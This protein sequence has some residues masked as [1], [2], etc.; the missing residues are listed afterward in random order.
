MTKT[1]TDDGWTCPNCGSTDPHHAMTFPQ[2]ERFEDEFE[3]DVTCE[4]VYITPVDGGPGFAF[5]HEEFEQAIDHFREAEY[6]SEGND[7]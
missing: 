1:D 2:E 7:E 3:V 5:R 4:S 6:T